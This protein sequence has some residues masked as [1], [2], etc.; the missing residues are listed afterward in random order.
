MWCTVSS[1]GIASVKLLK[2]RKKCM[3]QFFF[4]FK[5]IQWGKQRET[6]LCGI[7]LY[8]N[9]VA[10]STLGIK[11][12]NYVNAIFKINVY[13]AIDWEFTQHQV[14]SCYSI[15]DVQANLSSSVDYLVV[16]LFSTL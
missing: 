11:A 13:T 5:Y 7:L 14:F 12:T 15:P 9:K 8:S 4:Q 6:L 1:I 10:F 3:E 16:S 2:R